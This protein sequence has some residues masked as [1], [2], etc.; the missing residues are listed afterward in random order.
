MLDDVD[1][2]LEAAG[3]GADEAAED[4]IVTGVRLIRSHLEQVLRT[5]GVEEIPALAEAF[6]PHVHEAVMQVPSEE[7]PA[8]HVA[9]VLRR[10]YRIGDRVLRPARVAVARM[11]HA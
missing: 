10:G 2:A 6:D 3:S 4:P 8:G 9:Q 5:H 7:I 1:R 11:P